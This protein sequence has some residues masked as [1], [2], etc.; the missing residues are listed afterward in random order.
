MCRDVPRTGVGKLCK[1]LIKKL[2]YRISSVENPRVV[3]SIPSAQHWAVGN[4]KVV[5]DIA[6]P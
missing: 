4:R 2:L 1:R 6:L 3:G 5:D